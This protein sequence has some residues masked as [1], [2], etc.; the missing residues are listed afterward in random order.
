M[1]SFLKR[2]IK[3]PLVPIDERFIA[4]H[5]GLIELG[6]K[7]DEAKRKYFVE[8]YRLEG[9]KVEESLLK[10]IDEGERANTFIVHPWIIEKLVAIIMVG[11]VFM[12]KFYFNSLVNFAYQRS[13]TVQDIDTALTKVYKQRK[14]K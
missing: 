12:P 9:G 3:L 13:L 5:E 10:R 1:F 14:N 11:Q 8:M 6:I 4:L 2:N 7:V